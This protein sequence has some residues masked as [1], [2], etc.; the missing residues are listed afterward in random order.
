MAGPTKFT[1]GYD[2]SAYQAVTPSK[3]LP[4][5][6][7]DTDLDNIETSI[8]EIVD[9]IANVRRSDGK[10]QNGSVISDSLS[11][12]V[13]AYLVGLTETQAAR[14][15]S[16]GPSIEFFAA[17][18]QGPQ[19]SAPTTRSDGTAL[20]AGDSYYDTVLQNF[21]AY[22]GTGWRLQY[23]YDS[24]WQG[25]WATATTYTISDIVGKDGSSYICVTTHTSG[26]WATD[27]G[28]GYWQLFAAKGANGSGSGDMLAA[29]NLSDVVN[30]DTSLSNLGGTTVGR[31]VF[32][33]VTGAAAMTAQGITAVGQTLITAAT[34]AAQRTALGLKS[35]ALADLT[36][37]NDLSVKPGDIG[38]R[39]NMAA[40]IA[41]APLIGVGQTWQNVAF[42]RAINT[43]YQNT[44]GKP[45]MWTYRP[46]AVAVYNMQ[47]STDNTNWGTL[48][49]NDSASGALVN[50][51]VIV[52]DGHYYRLYTG[53][54]PGISIWQELR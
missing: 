3:P 52:P 45:I 15:E 22:D 38:T 48:Q 51:S 41:A 19:A 33:A 16:Y 10:L 27:I 6:E 31:A 7:L 30:A 26:D 50:G 8:S 25:N 12:E 11:P 20:Q 5:A 34:A 14:V 47:V 46:S 40:A 2:F 43:T 21:Y 17:V 35:A 42:S 18:Y 54:N 37:N 4:G 49:M 9:A 13:S 24:L 44:T 23:S 53:Q 29:N 39:G 32:K 36:D 1:R 28:A